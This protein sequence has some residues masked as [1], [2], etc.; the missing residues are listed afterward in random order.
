MH[1]CILTVEWPGLKDFG[2]D[3]SMASIYIDPG[4]EINSGALKALKRYV[5]SWCIKSGE[6]GERTAV[7]YLKPLRESRRLNIQRKEVTKNEDSPDRH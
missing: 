5:H 7:Y 6:S 4:G 3:E 1:S 2:K